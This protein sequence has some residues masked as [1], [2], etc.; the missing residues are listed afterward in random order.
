MAKVPIRVPV[1]NILQ[2][3]RVVRGDFAVREFRV[4]RK[5]R[6]ERDSA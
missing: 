1:V 5:A 3:G 2:P 6:F 4:R